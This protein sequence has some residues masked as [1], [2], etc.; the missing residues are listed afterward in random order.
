MSD[1]IAVI[2]YVVGSI[3]GLLVGYSI[4]RSLNR[5]MQRMRADKKRSDEM[6]ARLEA[7]EAHYKCERSQ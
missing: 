3:V 2:Y 7:A 5:D 4:W 1:E 6:W